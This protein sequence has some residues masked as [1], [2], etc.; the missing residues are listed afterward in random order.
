[1]KKRNTLAAIFLFFCL[2]MPNFV[3]AASIERTST[4]NLLELD[5]SL[6]HEDADEGWK[7]DAS[8]NTLTLNNVNFNVPISSNGIIFPSNK[9]VTVEVIGENTISAT[10]PLARS[11][12]LNSENV[13]ITGTGNLTLT[14]KNEKATTDLVNLTINSGNVIAINGSVNVIRKVKVNGGSLSVNTMNISDNGWTDGIYALEG[15]EVT[16]G[17]VDL[18]VKR[19]GMYVSGTKNSTSTDGII[20]TGGEVN[21]NAGLATMYVGNDDEIPVI[22]KDV[23]ITGGTVDF[24]SSNIGIY[25]L[26]GNITIN[27]YIK[28]S[29]GARIYLF[30]SDNSSKVLTIAPADF[31][32]LDN[33]LST[34]PTDLT[35]YTPETV[36]NLNN[37]L[38]SVN[39]LDRTTM[40][41]LNQ[42][43]IDQLVT[44]LNTAIT[45]LQVKAADFTALDNL[46]STV[47]T[48]LTVYTPETVTNLNNV[49]NSVNALDRTTM[50]ILNQAEIN[51]LVTNLNAALTN[52]EAKP[53]DFTT[54]DNLLSTVP[55]DLTIYTP[56][57]VTNLN[58]VLN[59]IKALDRTSM[60][61]LNQAKI[62]QLVT[63]LNAAL[64]N[65]QIKAADFTKLDNLLSTVPANLT[66]Y[67]PE[68]IQNLNDVL[69]SI[70]TLDRTAMN[71]LNQTVI[72]RLVTNLN[73]VLKSLQVKPANFTELDNLLSNV[74]TDLTIYT[75]ETVTNLN[76]VL[77]LV[78]ALDRTTM[79]ILN[80]GDIDILITKLDKANTDLQIKLADYSKVDELINSIDLSKYTESTVKG[81][82]KIV[83]SINRNINILNQEKV[84]AYVNELRLAIN[85]LKLKEVKIEKPI[86]NNT[87]NGNVSN[88]NQ[89][90]NNIHDNQTEKPNVDDKHDQSGQEGKTEQAQID[91]VG[92]N[93][94]LLLTISIVILLVISIF[95]IT[96]KRKVVK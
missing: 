1:M 12:A 72:D 82:K 43:E 90:D 77:N 30:Y 87:N 76:S 7:W 4:L 24:K 62:D 68:T 92:E 32:A 2:L 15:V 45:N 35:I 49:L 38:N 61:I 52:L 51:Q 17:K 28:A 91:N 10:V 53:A 78:N 9:D 11:G 58:N 37:V 33:L 81:F 13:I 22:R 29:T 16:N 60:N 56:E 19:V 71:I 93:N 86:I 96:K 59:S 5:L 74:S 73:A 80:Q 21:I 75:P 39:A 27:S 20:I 63:N 64:T 34:V 95:I 65:L 83:N 18:N 48:N 67:T 40:N 3:L 46:L 6:N 31:T 79:N 66:I 85:G 54:L 94:Y 47:P 8:Q 42:A 14:T 26:H 55:T 36:T 88:N 69:N 84:D 70:N 23:M 44:D 57:T 50:N 41:I 25:S 89:Q